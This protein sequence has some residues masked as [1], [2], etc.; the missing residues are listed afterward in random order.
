MAKISNVLNKMRRLNTFQIIIIGYIMVILVGTL[1]LMLPI[2]TRGDGGAPVF[3][4]LFTS[5]SAAC[6]TGL[7]VQDTATYWSE[8]GQ[9]MIMLLAEVGGLGSVTVTAWFA[10]LSGRKIGL[11]QRSTMQEAISAPKVGGVVKLAGFILKVTLVTELIGALM[12]MPVFCADFG[13]GRGIWYSVFHSISAFCNAGFDLM[14]INQQFSSLTAYEANPLVNLAVMMLITMGG[15]GFLTW[16]DMR[17]NKFNI[18]KYRMQ[19]KVIFVITAILIVLPF[20]YFFL[21]EFSGVPTVDKI[22]DSMFLTV[23]SRTAGYNSVDL[24]TLSETGIAIVII[25]ML[26]GGAPGSTAGGIKVTTVAVF[27]AAAMSVFRRRDYAKF[28]GRR[29]SDDTV[30]QAA[31]VILMYIVLLLAGTLIICSVEGLPLLTCLFEAA[32]AIGTVGLTLGITPQLGAI[33]KVILII[34]MFFGRA[35]GLT[36]IFATV[37]GTQTNLSKLPQE[38]I[39]VG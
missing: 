31:T 9:F 4:A 1:L 12:M 27:F 26:I 16:D 39:T 35:G 3:T 7:V 6:V 36:L 13:V 17:V 29:I 25:L 19:T 15:I 28:F 22:W 10:I 30:K 23:T 24:N 8:F 14:G 38:K 5:T 2:S 11:M 20:F 33:S 18:R 37:S 32:S 34:L 21:C